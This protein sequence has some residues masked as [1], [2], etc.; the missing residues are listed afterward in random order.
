M[1]GSKEG[2]IVSS[3]EQSEFR[4]HLSANDAITLLEFVH[5]C[6]S[7]NSREDFIALFPKLREILPFDFAHAFLGCH[8]STKGIVMAHGVNVSFPE[9]WLSEFIRNYIQE[10]VVVSENFRNYGLQKWSDS[11]MR[12]EEKKE[13]LSLCI[14]F[15]MRDGY[16]SGARATLP[17]KNGS[18]FCFSGPSLECNRRFEAILEF[19]TP[20]LHQAL[21]HL[22]NKVQ[23]NAKNIA[24]SVREKEVLNWLQQGKT[25]RDISIILAISERTVNYHVYNIME[26]LG[27]TNRPQAVAVATHSGLIDFN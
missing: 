7:C 11:K 2:F 22:F 20:H 23:Q 3:A 1:Y 18:M 10:D 13:I 19:V 27:V 25:S 12:L 4:R 8:D 24:I 26:K 14:D 9:E 15:G 6:L 17:D 5:N 21:S 16:S